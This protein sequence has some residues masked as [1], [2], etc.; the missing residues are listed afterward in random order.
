MLF[1]HTQNTFKPVEY[2]IIYFETH[3]FITVS[4][5]S[6]DNGVDDAIT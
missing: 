4:N 3:E 6:S 5:E 2:T 1:R